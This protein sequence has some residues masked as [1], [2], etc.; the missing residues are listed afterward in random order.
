M[1]DMEGAVN[2]LVE[3]FKEE[4]E[5]IAEDKEIETVI[6]RSNLTTEQETT[7]KEI[8]EETKETAQTVPAM[9]QGVATYYTVKEGDT[10]ISISKKMYHST[11]YVELIK[12]ANEITDENKIFPGDK[13][14]I[15]S[16]E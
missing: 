6:V 7:T 16:V 8:E 13:I 2:H 12:K 1:K 9:S 15:P 14:V 10:L 4:K 5:Y 11:K 3:Y